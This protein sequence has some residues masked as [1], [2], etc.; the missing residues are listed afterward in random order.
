M[1][2]FYL[3]TEE[4]FQTDAFRAQSL[5]KYTHL[6]LKTD[7]ALLLNLENPNV[8]Y[9]IIR[10]LFPLRHPSYI[11]GFCCSCYLQL[12]V[13]PLQEVLRCLSIKK[14][15][16]PTPTVKVYNKTVLEQPLSLTLERI[17]CPHSA[18]SGNRFVLVSN[19]TAIVLEPVNNCI[20]L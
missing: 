16:L 2:I 17:C 8:F 10:I 11:C 4:S 7:L 14:L 12:A 18:A 20:L 13:K 15:I 6:F 3:L 5:L 1:F 9:V 19:K